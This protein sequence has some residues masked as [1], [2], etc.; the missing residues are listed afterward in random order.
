V[1]DLLFLDF[2][3]EGLAHH[4]SPRPD[5]VIF[6]G[7]KLVYR[8][9]IGICMPGIVAVGTIVGQDRL[10]HQVLQGGGLVDPD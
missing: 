4:T 7:D 9:V 6:G 1:L 3:V 8:A 10:L 5:H 2:K